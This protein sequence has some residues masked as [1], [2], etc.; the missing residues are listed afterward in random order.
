MRS[1]RRSVATGRA[2][3]GE[4]GGIS[5]RVKVILILLGVFAAYGLL[6]YGVQRLLIYPSFVHLERQQATAEVE[7]AV[8]AVEREMDSLLP[9]AADWGLHS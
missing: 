7:R 6:D 4:R 1:L 2:A 8:E 3:T 9:T 5:L